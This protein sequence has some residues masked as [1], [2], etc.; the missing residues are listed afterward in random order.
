[1]GLRK[2]IILKSEIKI[3]LSVSKETISD[4]LSVNSNNLYSL[5]S[6]LRDTRQ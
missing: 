4:F 2:K 1:M 6:T 5:D 3:T